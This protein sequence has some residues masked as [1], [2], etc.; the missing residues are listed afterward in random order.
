[1]NAIAGAPY[2]IA[3]FSYF[4]FTELSVYALL[5]GC[6]IHAW[7]HR[8]GA[9]AYLLGGV[10]FGFLLEFFEVLTGSYSY[11]HFGLMLGRAPSDVP[12]FVGIAWGVI[13]YTARLFSD[14]MGLPILA[15][16]SLDTLLALSIDL[17]MDTVA[18]R[19]HFWNWDW[20][21]SGRNPLTADWFG[22]PY[23]NFVGWI[24]VVFCYSLFSRLIER[25]LLRRG[26][27]TV[28]IL[29]IPLLA[30][31]ASLGVLIST[32][33]LVFPVLNRVGFRSGSRWLTLTIVLVAL[34]IRG[35]S[36]R[37]PSAR[38]PHPLAIWAPGWFHV[39]F[40]FCFFALGFYRENVWMTLATVISILIGFLIHFVPPRSSSAHQMCAADMIDVCEAC[41]LDTVPPE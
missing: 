41:A 15:A 35:W 1:M 37:Q 2:P 8:N 14:A 30:L 25:W 23:G 33:L 17:S 11:G 31:I 22:I 40:V 10:G 4:L 36:R 6:I 9:L 38:K 39:F 27:S 32:E 18:Y 7:K 19:M 20:S 34:V 5:I 12:L 26:A 21:N 13:M 28:R 24:T 3:P 29:S 16:A